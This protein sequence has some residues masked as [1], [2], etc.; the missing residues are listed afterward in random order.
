MAWDDDAYYETELEIPSGRYGKLLAWPTPG[1]AGPAGPASTVPGPQGPPGPATISV[2][3]TVTSEPGSDAAVSNSGDSA[4]AVLDFVIPR[5]EQG[6]PGSGAEYMRDLLDVTPTGLAVGT[7]VDAKAGR[8]ALVAERDFQ[9]NVLDYGATGDGVTNDRVAIQNAINACEAAGGGVVLIPRGTYLVSGGIL[10][11][12]SD[13]VTVQGVGRSATILKTTTNHAVIEFESCSGVAV[14]DLQV[15]GD[16]DAAKGSQ[17]GVWFDYV[18]NGLVHNV[19]AKELGYDGIVLLRGC[20]YCTVSNCL[21]TDCADDGINIGGHPDAASRHN[22]VSGNI[23]RGMG[24]VG[25]HI[26]LN[27]E[28]TSVTGNTVSGCGTNGIDTFQSGDS[29]GQGRHSITGNTVSDCADSGIYLFNSDD[30]VVSGNTV[31]GG[32]RSIAVGRSLRSVISNNQC[33]GSTSTEPGAVFADNLVPGSSDLVVTGN[34]FS[35]VGGVRLVSPTIVFQGNRIKNATSS[36]TVLVEAADAV[37]SGNSISDCTG[38]G[39][40]VTGGNCVVSDNRVTGGTTQVRV[41]TNGGTVVS[42]N[43]LRGATV[44]GVEM[45]SNNCLIS[46]NVVSDCPTGITVTGGAVD[47]VVNGNAVRGNATYGVFV[48]TA[49]GTQVTNNRIAA[50]AGRAI[51]VTSGTNTLVAGNFTTSSG[52][53]SITTTQSTGTVIANNRFDATVSMSS[54]DINPIYRPLEA[55]VT[56]YGIDGYTA[57]NYHRS[58]WRQA[59]ATL[60]APTGATVVATGL[61]PDGAL[62]FGVT[63]RINTALGVTGAVKGYTVGTVEDPDLWG[64]LTGTNTTKST[65][66]KDFTDAA[67]SK[68]YLAA[69]DVVITATGGT[70]DGTGEIEVIAHYMICETSGNS[71]LLDTVGEIVEDLNS[72]TTLEGESVATTLEGVI[73]AQPKKRAPRK[74]TT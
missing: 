33:T 28:Y 62:L 37:L 67:A 51:Q 11:V 69:S 8:T 30:N 45:R 12:D 54:S 72:I 56:N 29:V 15:L 39:F 61:I 41:I 20:N 47:C 31:T 27:S 59:K 26:S 38:N 22:V 10:L 7:A 52:T 74:K 57:T 9:F 55:E 36:S 66:S 64:S 18:T 40:N 4:N 46:D 6:P 60:T 19:W 35:G 25:I 16:G 50:G 1:P 13:N 68:L 73:P 63:T 17:F 65:S 58:A 71:V 21:V 43:V 70:F 42:G 32:G 2:G 24:H 23:V 48:S 3:S 34:F 53:G 5:G 44:F 14:R 49:T